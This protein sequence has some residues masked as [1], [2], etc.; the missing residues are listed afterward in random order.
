MLPRQSEKHWVRRL[1]ISTIHCALGHFRSY[2]TPRRKQYVCPAFKGRDYLS[3]ISSALSHVLDLFNL[4]IHVSPLCFENI[5][6]VCRLASQRRLHT[7]AGV[8]IRI[9]LVAKFLFV[10]FDVPEQKVNE[11]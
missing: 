2:G 6:V 4:L 7:L 11:V 1:R 5:Q 10:V 8:T 3:P 9:G